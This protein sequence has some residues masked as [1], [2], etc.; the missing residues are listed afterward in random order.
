MVRHS[1]L[2]RQRPHNAK[3]RPEFDSIPRPHFI[4]FGKKETT[5]EIGAGGETAA[6]DGVGVGHGRGDDTPTLGAIEGAAIA[7]GR[8]TFVPH[9]SSGRR[10]AAVAGGPMVVGAQRLRSAARRADDSH[11]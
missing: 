9:E 3:A 4:L 5:G 11:P 10:G 8:A 7:G 2:P 6:A 1:H